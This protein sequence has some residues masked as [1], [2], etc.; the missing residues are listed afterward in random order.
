MV[1]CQYNRV[2][3]RRLL[4]QSDYSPS[5]GACL[6]CRTASRKGNTNIHLGSVGRIHPDPNTTDR[7][8]RSYSNVLGS[9]S[10]Q[11]T[12][13][14]PTEDLLFRFIVV[15]RYRPYHPS[16]ANTIDMAAYFVYWQEDQDC[17]A[18]WGWRDCHSLNTLSGF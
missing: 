7:H 12:L 9:E 4:H 6:C 11:C 16:R 3:P 10:P 8:L 2:Y 17:A 18:S 13:P 5:H 15:N 14:Q 1:L